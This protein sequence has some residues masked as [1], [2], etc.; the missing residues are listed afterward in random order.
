MDLLLA[1]RNPGSCRILDGVLR[2]AVLACDAADASG[3]VVPLEALDVLDLEGLNEEVV[4]AQEGHRVSL[5]E[6]KHEG[7]HVVGGLLQ[8]AEVLRAVRV[9]DLDG[10]PPSVHP[11]LELQ[12]LHERLDERYPVRL[13]GRHPLW[14]HRHAPQLLRRATLLCCEC[15]E[16][17]PVVRSTLAGVGA[18]A[19]I[20]GRLDHD[21]FDL[22]RLEDDAV[23]LHA[24]VLPPHGLVAGLRTRLFHEVV[25]AIHRHG[26]LHR[27]LQVLA[28]HRL[29]GRLIKVRATRTCGPVLVSEQGGKRPC[30]AMMA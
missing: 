16:L 7:L 21:V 23:G 6:A 10:S 19:I 29:W 4:Q 28:L 11:N 1:E 30:Q 14:R 13:E 2:L 18:G 26:R 25:I 22:R 24:L 3:Q 5:V 8:G 20:R 17:R 15:R 9:T 12:V 27:L